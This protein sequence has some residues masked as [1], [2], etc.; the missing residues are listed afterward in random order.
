M[1]SN[2]EIVLSWMMDVI[3]EY[4]NGD[5]DSCNTFN[6]AVNIY[7]EFLKQLTL[8]N[9]SLQLLAAVAILISSKFCTKIVPLKISTLIY[10]SDDS[11]TCNDIVFMERFVLSKL[12]WKIFQFT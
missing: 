12:Q 4:Y 10:Y 6:L 1:T 5:S 11:L 2:R 8:P 7:D 3:Q 9:H